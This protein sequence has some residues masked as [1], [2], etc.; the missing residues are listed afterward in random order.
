MS[1]VLKIVLTCLIFGAI[2]LASYK[3]YIFLNRKI[4]ESQTGWQLL[5]Y[6][7]TLFVVLAGLYFGGF[8]LLAY[9]YSFLKS[10]E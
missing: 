4:N 6:S 2:L 8:W 3:W 10:G 1:P 9:V 7:I 5:A